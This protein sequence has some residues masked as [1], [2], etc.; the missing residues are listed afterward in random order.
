MYKHYI[1][2][3]IVVR[4][5]MGR[6]CYGPILLWAEMS[7]DRIADNSPQQLAPRQLAPH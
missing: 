6:N 5:C 1:N 2:I 4:N 7:S 3:K